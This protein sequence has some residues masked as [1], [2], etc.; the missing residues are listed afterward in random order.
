MIFAPIRVGIEARQGRAILRRLNRVEYERTVQDLLGISTPL[1]G[2]LPADTPM[3]GFDTVAEGLRLSTL[4]MERYLDA[5]DAALDDAITFAAEPEHI[6][7]RAYFKDEKGIRKDIDTPEGT[8]DNPTD[9]KSKHRQL[10]LQLPDDSI[11]FFNPGYPTADTHQL[12]QHPAGDYRVRISAYAYQ[13]AGR[14]V[15]MR[16][17]DDNY[18]TK[19]LLGWYEIPPD[20]PRIVEINAHLHENTHLRIETTYTGFDGKGRGIYNMPVKEFTGA[21]LALQWAELEGPKVSEW[22]PAS[23]KILFGDI[24]LKKIEDPKKRPNRK[25]AFELA[26]EDPHAAARQAIERFAARAFRRPL[27]E[28]EAD[29]FVKLVS[30]EL[31][32]GTAFPE[33]MRV[34]FRAILTAPQFLLFQEAPGKLD[35]YALASRL[36]YFL[37]STMPDG[38]LLELAAA[39]KLSDPETLHAQVERMLN[40]PRS[41]AFVSNFTGQWLDLR[42]IDATTPD[43]KLYPES[44]ELLRVS[45]VQETEKFFAEMLKE[46][47]S[48]TN[49]VQS[50]F[51]MLNSRLAVHYGIAGVAGEEFRKVR[52]PPDSPRGGLFTQASVL[53]VTAN[54]TTT[55]PVH[56]R[57]LD[58]ET[59]PRTAA[60]SAA[61]GHRDHRARYPRRDDRPRAACQA[62]DAGDLRRVPQQDR[63]AGLRP[64]IVRRHRR[65]PRANTAPRIKG[66]R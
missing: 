36:S 6:D 29:R 60:E 52:L 37:W 31:D 56:P 1:A 57:R 13:S 30:D 50:D 25:N 55:S 11:V 65:I 5:A 14:N 41:A 53:K 35:E 17:Y 10:M 9:P 21:G 58:H 63:S 62:S 16:V 61:A 64:R 12:E 27:A 43:P 28:G 44:D 38:T 51:A 40:D 54:G 3:Y 15:I 32:N 24:P 66:V 34:G 42:N 48:Y 4:Q 33:A 20:E 45:M 8:L 49:I 26:P 47:L 39:K 22:P 23:M 2:L 19:D 7:K 59:N 18:R 46:N